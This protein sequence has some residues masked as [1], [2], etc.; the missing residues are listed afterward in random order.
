LQRKYSSA[1]LKR[2]TK[3]TDRKHSIDCYF[4]I[5]REEEMNGSGRQKK[6]RVK[7][8]NGVGRK[9]KQR[10]PDL[11]SFHHTNWMMELDELLVK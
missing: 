2:S 11:R 3:P 10:K 4:L 8:N 5:Y 1:I 6:A 9:L 7:W